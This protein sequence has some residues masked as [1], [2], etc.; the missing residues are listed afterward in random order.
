[1]LNVSY[2]EDASSHFS[3]AGMSPLH[4]AAWAGQVEV[5]RLMVEKG[6]EVNMRS[7]TGETPLHLACQHGNI[8]VVKNLML[9]PLT[10]Q[11]QA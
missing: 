4:L 7:S 5:A 3:P 2:F 10:L 6:A 11:L 9:F 8:E 1:M